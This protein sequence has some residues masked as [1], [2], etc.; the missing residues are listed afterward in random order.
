MELSQLQQIPHRRFNPLSG[1]WVLVSPNRTQRPWLGKQ[2]DHPAEQQSA[3]DPN[4]YLCPG[5]ERAA[6]NRNPL[7]KSTFVFD[8]DYPALLPDP[9]KINADESGLIVARSE[10]GLCRVICFSPRH[11]L[12]ISRMNLPEVRQVV[13][14]WASESESAATIPWVG[15]VQ[16]FEN[17]G[18]LMGASN[19]HPHCQVW[20]TSTVPNVPAKEHASFLEYQDK[21]HSCLLCDYL[22]LELKHRERIVCENE[23]FVVL[24]PYWAIWPFET[25]VLSRRH[26]GGL[27]DLSE[28]ERTHLAEILR[29]VTI[30][31][32]NVFEAPFP[33]SM[34]FHQHPPK[35]ER[36][37]DW[38][39]HAHYLPPL[40]RSISVRKFMVGFELLG[41]PQRD[42]TPEDA[43]VRLLEARDAHYL[44]GQS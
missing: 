14:V 22:Q 6:G 39:L 19:P 11:D 30:C 42:I 34:G 3:Y 8:N 33:Y 23:S 27:G 12:T 32:D 41:T 10:A 18:E 26:V 44:G 4:C 38:H 35:S 5:N 7:Y 40:L 25:M 2:E 29:Q 1:E 15:Y 28:L 24:V 37:N 21:H 16:I 20:A 9:P 17:R 36:G 13:D 43:A 31:Y